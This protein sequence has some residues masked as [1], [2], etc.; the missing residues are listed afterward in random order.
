M[1]ATS[2][3][4][5]LAAEQDLPGPACRSQ[6]EVSGRRGWQR[7]LGL[8]RERGTAKVATRATRRRRPSRWSPWRNSRSWAA[9]RPRSSSPCGRP[10]SSFLC[11]R[12]EFA[13]QRQSNRRWAAAQVGSDGGY[14]GCRRWLRQLLGLAAGEGGRSIGEWGLV[15]D[16]RSEGF[17]FFFAKSEMN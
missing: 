7:W 1:A 11:E 16:S 3:R 14:D 6:R 17:F 4:G 13:A 9:G 12:C 2:P 5:R 15:G 8:P 10:R